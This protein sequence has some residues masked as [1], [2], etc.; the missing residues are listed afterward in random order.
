MKVVRYKDIDHLD[1][2]NDEDIL[3][4]IKMRHEED[5]GKLLELVR[6]TREKEEEELNAKRRISVDAYA[7][8][9]RLKAD[10]EKLRK[11][12]DAFEETVGRKPHIDEVIANM[13]DTVSTDS[14]ERFKDIL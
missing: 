2:S 6:I 5:Q 9:I 10:T 4:C 3:D 8:E 1:K 11:Y 13:K 7:H 14:I 12:V